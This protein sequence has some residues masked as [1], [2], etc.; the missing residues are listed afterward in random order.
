MALTRRAIERDDEVVAGWVKEVWPCAEDSRRPV[1]PWLVFEDEAGFSMTP[2]Q[3]RPGHS[4][5]GLR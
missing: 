1:E 5:A 3:A 2:P 4:A